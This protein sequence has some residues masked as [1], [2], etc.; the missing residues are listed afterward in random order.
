MNVT[1]PNPERIEPV[2]ANTLP[3]AENVAANPWAAVRLESEPMR[4]IPPAT[5]DATQQMTVNIAL[6]AALRSSLIT[7]LASL[8]VL[9]ASA[10]KLST[11]TNKQ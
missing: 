10:F 11:I 2:E 4:P 7:L 3:P 1:S 5:T 6:R 8:I 9:C